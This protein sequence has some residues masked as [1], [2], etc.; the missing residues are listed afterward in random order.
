MLAVLAAPACGDTAAKEHTPSTEATKKAPIELRVATSQKQTRAVTLTLDGTLVAD[1]ESDVTSVVSGRVL[2][3]LVE[4]GSKVEKGAPLVKLR[5]VDY[6]LQAR[7][8]RAQLEQARARLGMEKNSAPPKPAELPEVQAAHSDMELAQQDLARAKEL[9]AAGALT[10]QELDAS[11]ARAVATENRYQ[12]AINQ[13]Q[14][15]VSAL[16]SA[17]VAIDQAKTSVSEAT[18]RA[19]FAGEIARRNVSVGE[20]VAPQSPLLTLV[21]VDPLRIELAVPQQHLRAVQPGQSV[22]LRIDA[23]PGETFQA[24]VRYVSAALTRDTRSLTVEALV[25]NPDGRLRPGLFATARLDTGREETVAV[26]P[27]AAVRTVAGVSRV[28]VIEDGVVRER[29]VSVAEQIDGNTI[30]A[31]GLSSGATIAVEK[32]DLLTDGQPVKPIEGGA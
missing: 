6:R 28:F 3:V 1:L 27:D 25:P 26:V 5:D 17:R 31:D 10:Q 30:I 11:R 29:V 2:E 32:L 13:A 8:A 9:A 18:V 24:T 12:N 19:P 21:R 20:F 15:A 7:A 16:E 22:S 4:R 14:G 23:L